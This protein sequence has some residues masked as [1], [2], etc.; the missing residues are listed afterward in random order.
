[1]LLHESRIQQPIRW[2]LVLVIVAVASSV[3][4]QTNGRPE[5]RSL[6]LY[7]QQRSQLLDSALSEYKKLLA[8]CEQNNLRSGQTLMAK[9][10]AEFDAIPGELPHKVVADISVD[11]PPLERQWQTKKRAI[12][13]QLAID[14]NLLARRAINADQASFAFD[15]VHEAGKFDPD[16]RAVRKLLG[17]VQSDEEWVTPFQVTMER[18]RNIWHPT[19]GWINKA[20]VENYAKGMRR[21]KG[22]WISA[23]KEAAIRSDFRNAWQIETEHFLIKTNH[24]LERGV[25]IAASLEEFHHYFFRTFAAFFNTPQQMKAL[26][27]NGIRPKSARDKYEVHYYRT[28]D[29]YNQKLVSK[30]PMIAQTNGLY[31]M[32]TRTSYFY[33]NPADTLGTMYH[34]ATHQFLYENS[35]SNRLIAEDSD[36]WIVEGIACYME[37][38][39]KNGDKISVGSARH[40]RII[41]AQGTLL[42]DRFY[43]PLANFSAMGRKAFQGQGNL[44]QVYSQVGGLAHFFMHYE[45][46]KY[47]DALIT[48]LAKLYEPTRG[49]VLVPSLAELTD[50]PFATLDQQYATYIQQL[51]QNRRP[52]ARVPA[53]Q[54]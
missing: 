49:T 29:E 48:H 53:A 3:E 33:H 4:A 51:N 22:R 31:Y 27:V 54:R 39:Q 21:Y 25:E 37:S 50:T 44:I 32:G 28:R 15:L 34:E 24:S 9:A 30:I 17:F 8:F 41:G 13:K 19:F 14:M 11:L 52:R 20:Y 47:R 40:P 2:L 26:F 6:Q 45:N 16:N 35:A 7:Q 42:R 43:I 46:G 10:I 23:E 12:D 18:R 5:A 36:F 1:M 38:F